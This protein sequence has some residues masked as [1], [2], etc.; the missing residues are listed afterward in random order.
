MGEG[1]HNNHH[2]YLNSARQGFRW[3][4]IDL[5]YYV[6]RVLALVGLIW[7]VKGV[8]AHIA[9]ADRRRPR[10]RTPVSAD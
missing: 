9:D 7:D 4:Q 5:T 1:W 2:H 8:P 10:L 3:Y 6:L